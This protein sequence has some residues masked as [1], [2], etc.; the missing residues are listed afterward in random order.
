MGINKKKM[1]WDED[2]KRWS[3]VYVRGKAEPWW[4]TQPVSTYL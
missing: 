3:E 4:A 1:G 2:G